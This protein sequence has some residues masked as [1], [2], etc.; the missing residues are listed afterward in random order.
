[1]L[2]IN[3]EKESNAPSVVKDDAKHGI[4]SVSTFYSTQPV[5]REQLPF[6][7]MGFD[8]DEIE[9]LMCEE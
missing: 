3:F 7:E 2:D 5:K 4:A 1:M 6:P 9:L 8:F